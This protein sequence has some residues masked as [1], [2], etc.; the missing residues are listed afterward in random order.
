MTSILNGGFISIGRSRDAHPTPT[1]PKF[2]NCM[3]FF[4]NF[5]K[6]VCWRPSGGLASPGILDQSLIRDLKEEEDPNYS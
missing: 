3:Q 6:I 4:G 1:V 5:G 2:L